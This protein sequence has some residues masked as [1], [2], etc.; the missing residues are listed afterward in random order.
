MRDQHRVGRVDDH[1]VLHA[2]G[3]DHAI[4]GVHEGAA[5]VDGHALAAAAIAV[6]VGVGELGDRLPGADVA[7]VEVAAHHGHLAVGRGVLHDRVV[8]GDIGRDGEGRRVDL[9]HRLA[10]AC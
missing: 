4:L 3:G 1:E 10:V 7:P 9:E 6:G 8:D 2:D 5:G